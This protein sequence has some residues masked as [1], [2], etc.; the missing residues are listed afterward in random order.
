MMVGADMHEETGLA[1]PLLVGVTDMPAHE[2]Y[3][4]LAPNL[5]AGAYEL[6]E[7]WELTVPR[8][9]PVCDALE[10]AGQAGARE[11]VIHDVPVVASAS[12]VEGEGAS[13]AAVARWA[14]VRDV[15]RVE[16]PEALA[17]LGCYKVKPLAADGSFG[18]RVL[19]H[20][21]NARTM[22]DMAGKL[23]LGRE[24]SKFVSYA[25][26]C[27]V[28]PAPGAGVETFEDFR[29]F[30]GG[31]V[32]AIELERADGPALGLTWPDWICHNPDAHL[33]L[34]V[35]FAGAGARYEAFSGWEAGQA[36]TLRI[37]A[38]GC[39]DVE[40]PLSLP[41]APAREFSQGWYEKQVA[42]A[43]TALEKAGLDGKEGL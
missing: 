14:A 33:E 30:Y 13:P 40:F 21:A 36:C 11:F 15:C 1:Y 41:A 43:R 28:E 6:P 22:R 26:A 34:G 7:L 23:V 18:R 29:A 5:D 38:R 12:L 3:Q 27:F 8:Y 16:T 2:F 25:Y 42:Q 9:A 17:G 10:L 31:D 37:I 4:A 39:L 20:P 24:F 35:L 19:L 32:Y